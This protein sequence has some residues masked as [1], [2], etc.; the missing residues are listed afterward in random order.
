VF[1][2]LLYGGWTAYAAG[3]HFQRTGEF[4][5]VGFDPDLL[6]RST[7]WVALFAD[8]DYG[9]VAWQPAW[10]LVV[11]AVGLLW[12]LGGFRP[13]VAAAPVRG[14]L[15]PGALTVLLAPLGAGLITAVYVALTMHGFWWPGRQLVVVLPLAAMVIALA[16]AHPALP[17]R[18]LCL[19]VAGTLAAVGVAI[20][21]WVLVAGYTADLTWVGAP[22]MAPPAALGAL[23]SV[24]PDY[25]EL[26]ASTWWTHAAWGLA[27]LVLLFGGRYA[28]RR[29][30]PIAGD[31][32]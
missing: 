24:L 1:H 23:R 3:D 13:D 19:L 5:A 11:P 10:L 15:H 21:A 7:R 22:D 17:R 9:L 4:S 8:R 31:R 6:G 16:L 29:V 14:V 18:R 28:G 25:R 2:Q 12:G 27:L 26:G 20:H 32:P 30:P